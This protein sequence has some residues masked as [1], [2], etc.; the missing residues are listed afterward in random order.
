LVVHRNRL[1]SGQKSTAGNFHRSPPVHG[2]FR[3]QLPPARTSL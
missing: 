3:L 2:R 1:T